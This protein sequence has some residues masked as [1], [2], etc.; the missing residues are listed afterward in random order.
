MRLFVESIA[1]ADARREQSSKAK[2]AQLASNAIA[3]AAGDEPKLMTPCKAGQNAADARDET[4]A[5][6][7]IL[8][9]PSAVG[10]IPA[11][12]RQF[13]GAIDAVPIR[14]IILG[15]LVEAPGNAHLFEHRE[16]RGGIGGVGVEKCAVPIEEHALQCMVV[17][18]HSLKN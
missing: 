14:R 9:A 7:R 12:A 5:V 18:R 17:R 16:V 6:I 13:C 1:A 10:G 4:R 2:L 8:F 3:I 15:K 11:S